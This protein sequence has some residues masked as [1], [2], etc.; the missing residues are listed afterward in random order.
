VPIELR[1][2]CS[3][4]DATRSAVYG[5]N[6]DESDALSEITRLIMRMASD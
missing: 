5:T 2:D 6:Y 4:E 3:D 1:E